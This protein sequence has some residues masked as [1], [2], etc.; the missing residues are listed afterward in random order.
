MDFPCR[1]PGWSKCFQCFSNEH[2][3]VALCILESQWFV[4]MLAF[5]DI[6]IAQ[7]L[8]IVRWI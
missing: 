3:G 6:M 1:E 8:V 2:P 5:V 7:G 4:V